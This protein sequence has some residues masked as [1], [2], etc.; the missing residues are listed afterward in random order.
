MTVFAA[1]YW[2]VLSVALVAGDVV[3]NAVGG[4]KASYTH[5]LA[6]HVPVAIRVA[7]LAWVVYHF[8]VQHVTG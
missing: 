5:Y 8:L 1:V 2:S 3:I 4:E 6:V 7:L